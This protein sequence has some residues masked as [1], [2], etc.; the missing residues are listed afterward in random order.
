MP[1]LFCDDV[2]T[3]KIQLFFG[4]T[5]NL[6]LLSIYVE[7]GMAPK[8][9]SECERALQMQ[10]PFPIRYTSTYSD[11]LFRFFAQTRIFGRARGARKPLLREVVVCGQRVA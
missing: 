7:I 5:L 6:T 8:T 2:L 4:L 9:L 3:C 1:P 10:S 11:F